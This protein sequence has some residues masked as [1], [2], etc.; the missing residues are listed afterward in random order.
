MKKLK[1][2]FSIMFIGAFMAALVTYCGYVITSQK[3]IEP[4][5]AKTLNIAFR[6]PGGEEIKR[7]I[8]YVNELYKQKDSIQ[9][10][11]LDAQK[12][13]ADVASM[14]PEQSE[15]Y[16]QEQVVGPMYANGTKI[17]EPLKAINAQEASEAERIDFISM[18]NA[19]SHQSLQK[20]LKYEAI[21][22]VVL[23]ILIILL[24]TGVRRLSTPGILILIGS[25]P[26]LLLFSSFNYMT[27]R[28]IN[29]LVGQ[30]TS[31][32]IYDDFLSEVAHPLVGLLR[33]I[34]LLP[35]ILGAALIILAIIM[36]QILRQKSPGLAK[37]AFNKGG[38]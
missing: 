3:V 13:Q 33:N 21:A 38:K 31:S 19:K 16:I 12:V 10:M 25:L 1:W 18:A 34:Y 14:S 32:P 4:L 5:L 15:K 17:I 29:P 30:Y 2:L 22:L 20:T 8:P 6:Q 37:L 23:L 36:G 28:F 35:A 27:D 24:S 11:A 7:I 9:A 26:G